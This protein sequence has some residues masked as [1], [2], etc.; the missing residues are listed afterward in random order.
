MIGTHAYAYTAVG[1]WRC[2]IFPGGRAER[3]APF[4]IWA[5]FQLCRQWGTWAF[6]ICGLGRQI[7]QQFLPFSVSW[8]CIPLEQ[9]NCL[10]RKV[11][12]HNTRSRTSCGVC[13]PHL[14]MGELISELNLSMMNVGVGGRVGS[15]LCPIV[16]KDTEKSRNLEMVQHWHHVSCEVGLAV[17]LVCTSAHTKP[18]PSIAATTK[19]SIKTCTNC[20]GL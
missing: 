9:K 4:C 17:L 19:N 12:L 2:G 1:I 16:A 14:T 11:W 13:E 20:M 8:K 5:T 15:A 6:R 3:W 10:R 18:T 7:A